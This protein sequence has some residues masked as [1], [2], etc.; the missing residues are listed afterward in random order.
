MRLVFW[1]VIFALI[2][3]LCALGY[4]N[5]IYNRKY[6][7]KNQEELSMIEENESEIGNSLSIIMQLEINRRLAGSANLI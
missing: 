4:S 3:F 2:F 1:W 7:D 5:Y 6:K